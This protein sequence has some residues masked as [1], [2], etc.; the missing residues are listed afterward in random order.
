MSAGSNRN[1]SP[2]CG[3]VLRRFPGGTAGCGI[4]GGSNVWT[5]VNTEDRMV[6]GWYALDAQLTAKSAA[7]S[8]PVKE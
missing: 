3:R 5:L 4:E 7:L 6:D 1:R 2:L 8:V